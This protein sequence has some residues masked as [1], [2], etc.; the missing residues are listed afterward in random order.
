MDPLLQE[1]LA[2]I[3]QLEGKLAAVEFM[4]K[5][6]D[7]FIAGNWDRIKNAEELEDDFADQ[8]FHG[9]QRRAFRGPFHLYRKSADAVEKFR[10]ACKDGELDWFCWVAGQNLVTAIGDIT[11]GAG[12]IT[13]DTDN[14]LITIAASSYVWLEFDDHR[15]AGFPKV[16]IHCATAKPDTTADTYKFIEIYPLWYVPFVSG[17]V[18]FNGKR[19]FRFSYHLTRMG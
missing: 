11:V 10:I 19:D 8:D 1:A 4:A 13:A 15:G 3:E 18:T 2:R 16:R 17:K 9:P 6:T 7:R 5:G 14:W 12:T